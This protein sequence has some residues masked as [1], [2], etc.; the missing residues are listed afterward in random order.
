ML[1]PKPNLDRIRLLVEALRSKNN[2][3]TFGKLSNSCLGNC[4]CVE[5]LACH[6]FQTETNTG[7]WAGD[8]TFLVGN[9]IGRDYAP[10]EVKE[11][12]G[13]PFVLCTQPGTKASFLYFNDELKFSFSKFADLLEAE[14]LC[15]GII[16]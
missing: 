13:I 16:K 3:Q 14:Y 4:F 2:V 1:I 8:R 15:S 7:V 12:F 11:W 6:V 10:T 5:G 9:S